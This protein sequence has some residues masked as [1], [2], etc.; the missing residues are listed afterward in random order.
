LDAVTKAVSHTY[1]NGAIAARIA[2]GIAVVFED[3][4]EDEPLW[5]AAIE[6][7]RSAPIGT[8]DEVG[9]RVDGTERTVGLVAGVVA[10]VGVQ[11]PAFLTVEKDVDSDRFVQV[12]ATDDGFRVES[13]SDV[14]LTD[15]LDHRELAV[16]RE[17]GYRPPVEDDC[18]NWHVDVGRSVGTVARL[19]IDT[20][21]RVHDVADEDEISLSPALTADHPALAAQ[22]E[23]PSV[24]DVEEPT[25]DALSSALAERLQAAIDTVGID[26]VWL[27]V[28]QAGS[29]YFAHLGANFDGQLFTEVTGSFYLGTDDVLSDAQ[30]GRLR[31]LGWGDP[32][33]DVDDDEEVQPR[34]H[35]RVWP[36]RIDVHAAAWHVVLT[37]SAVYGFD[38]ESPW[39]ATAELFE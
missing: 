10:H 20:M 9:V 33:P 35:T 38:L 29:P 37:L 12:L 30:V 34:N 23:D 32:V 8:H 21:R 31:S 3:A 36:V 19:V 13:P 39:H 24:L 14:F 28:S 2:S 16:M 1:L 22:V 5:T 17:L 18:L 4:G 7:L 25:I 6:A 15:P 26:A 11:R 27:T